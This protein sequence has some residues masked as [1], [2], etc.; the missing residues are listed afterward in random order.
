MVIPK[1]TINSELI[2]VPESNKK[3]YLLTKYSELY[4]T[5]KV[6]ALVIIDE[7]R[8][9][10]NNLCKILRRQEFDTIKFLSKEH[11]TSKTKVN[12]LMNIFKILTLA[13][14]LQIKNMS[15]IDNNKFNKLMFNYNICLRFVEVYCNVDAEHI[16]TVLTNFQNDARYSNNKIFKTISDY[17]KCPD[18]CDF[19][20][21]ITAKDSGSP[22]PY[23]QKKY[24]YSN[25]LTKFSQYLLDNPPSYFNINQVKI[26]NSKEWM[27]LLKHLSQEKLINSKYFY[28]AYELLTNFLIKLNDGSYLSNLSKTD[29][30]D[31]IFILTKQAYTVFEYYEKQIYDILNVAIRLHFV[32]LTDLVDNNISS[33]ADIILRAVKSFVYSEHPEMLQHI[34]KNHEDLFTAIIL[35]Q[36]RNPLVDNSP[37]QFSESNF[38]DL[39]FILTVKKSKKE[40]LCPTYVTFP[41]IFGEINML[42]DSDFH[43][44][45][46]ATYPFDTSKFTFHDETTKNEYNELLGINGKMTKKAVK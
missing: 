30:E 41:T 18:I 32:I 6:K 43:K 8:D 9:T 46:Y 37:S 22:S 4:V 25:Y 21:V 16:S 20:H 7:N 26:N 44:N 14:K 12:Y 31:F 39:R 34:I 23:S 29:A 11:I 33:C 1:F 42:I 28:A 36:M 40:A 35:Y 24:S 19:L 2:Q 5:K 3:D 10:Y 13:D 15:Y 17:F 27:D 38:I 45:L